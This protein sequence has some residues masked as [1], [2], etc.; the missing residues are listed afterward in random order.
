M[1]EMW[2]DPHLCSEEDETTEESSHLMSFEGIDCRDGFKDGEECGEGLCCDRV[3]GSISPPRLDEGPSLEE[4]G[5]DE[6]AG[7]DSREGGGVKAGED[8]GEKLRPFL[9]PI[10]FND[11]LCTFDELDSNEG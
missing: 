2:G 7:V 6:E 11:G 3:D 8:G 5:E 9:W 10:C 4:A 1:A